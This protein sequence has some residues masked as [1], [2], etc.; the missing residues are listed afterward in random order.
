MD[1]SGFCKPALFYWEKDIYQGFPEQTCGLKLIKFFNSAASPLKTVLR[2]VGTAL[3][4]IF[5][6]HFTLYG[7]I[8]S[9]TSVD[10]SGG[11]NL[12]EFAY[13]AP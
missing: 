2:V 4:W 6:L 10:K 1:C 13:G 3:L 7:K 8:P 5:I 11:D 12:D 9:E